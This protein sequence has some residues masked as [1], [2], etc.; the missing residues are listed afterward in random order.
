M[1]L[2]QAIKI[3]ESHNKWR[4]DNNILPKATM[5]LENPYVTAD[6]TVRR[7]S[8]KVVRGYVVNKNKTK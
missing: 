2:K 3:V 1:T 4:R 5:V 6:Q 8:S 7:M